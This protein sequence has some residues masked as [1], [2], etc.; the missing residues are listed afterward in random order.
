MDDIN[1]YILRG[2]ILLAFRVFDW[3]EPDHK[4]YWK[5]Q[6]RSNAVYMDAILVALCHK[7]SSQSFV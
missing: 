4:L 7:P 6:P 1:I 2:I 3:L 5:I